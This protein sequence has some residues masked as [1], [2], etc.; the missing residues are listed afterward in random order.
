M[1]VSS[2]WGITQESNDEYPNEAIMFLALLGFTIG[3]GLFVFIIGYEIIM[4]ITGGQGI[5]F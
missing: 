2:Y 5:L 3:A 4:L 1:A